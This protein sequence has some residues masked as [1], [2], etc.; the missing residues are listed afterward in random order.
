MPGREHPLHLLILGGTAEAAGLARAAFE[1]F[2]A[3][4]LVTTSLAGRTQHPAPLPGAV[5][6]GGF[7]GAAGLAA[8]LAESGVNGVIDATHPFAA[9]IS[10]QAVEACTRAQVPRLLLQRPPWRRHPSDRWIEVEDAAG[11]AEALPALGRRVFLTIGMRD[12]AAF[13]HLTNMHF[14]V[15]LIDAPKEELPLAGA[16]LLVARGPFTLAGERVILEQNGI[17]VLV[18]KASGGSATEAKLVAARERGLPV[19]MLRR[20]LSAAGPCVESVQAALDWLVQTLPR[21]S[22]ER[23]S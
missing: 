6:I 23:T 8:Y 20:P 18:A 22:E 3:D 11:A 10:R 17:E 4:L 16:E 15:R 5:R 1:R 13:A 19:V 21:L 14:F 7:S 9:Q 2:G 12:L